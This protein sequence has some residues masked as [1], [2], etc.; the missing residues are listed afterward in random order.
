MSCLY[1]LVDGQIT[2][3]N[4][5][6]FKGEDKIDLDE[7]SYPCTSQISVIELNPLIGFEQ[8]VQYSLV[9]KIDLACKVCRKEV[10]FSINS[11]EKISVPDGSFLSVIAVLG[12]L[13]L[14]LSKKKN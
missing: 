10:F 8:N 6:L 5:K 9:G 13:L 12:I 2:N 11:N 1:D 14:F 7:S 4:L 3:I